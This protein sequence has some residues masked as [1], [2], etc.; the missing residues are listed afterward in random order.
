MEAV[1]IGYKDA[2]LLQIREVKNRDYL[3]SYVSQG[4]RVPEGSRIVSDLLVPST[5]NQRYNIQAW[6]RVYEFTNLLSR[7][8]L[9]EPLEIIR[10]KMKPEISSIIAQMRIYFSQGRASDWVIGQLVK[11]NLLQP[12]VKAFSSD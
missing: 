9:Y 5:I 2:K 1:G 6:R 11:N 12:F 3:S 10:I 8:Q 4:I 7:L